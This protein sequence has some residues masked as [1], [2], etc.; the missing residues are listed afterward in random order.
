MTDG[1]K[2]FGGVA[3]V[4]TGFIV[5]PLVGVLFGA[6][7]GWIVGLFFEHTIRA[8]MTALKL[9]IPNIE[10]WQLGA[11]LGFVGAF[12]RAHQSNSK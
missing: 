10:I 1:T 6:F 11:T 5:F 2:I 8:T 9:P 3:L 7:S 4:A 12:F